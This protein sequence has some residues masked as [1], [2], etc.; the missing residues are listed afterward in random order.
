MSGGSS[1]FMASTST[2][3][4]LEARKPS[5]TFSWGGMGGAHAFSATFP[6]TNDEIE[7]TST[8]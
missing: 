3:T 6:T 5:S 4:L 8:E 7:N 1:A 2:S